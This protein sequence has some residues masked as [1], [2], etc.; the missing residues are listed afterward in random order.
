MLIAEEIWIQ[1]FMRKLQVH[2]QIIKKKNIYKRGSRSFDDSTDFVL[3]CGN[4]GRGWRYSFYLTCAANHDHFKQK[5]RRLMVSPV[6]CPG[7]RTWPRQ[8]VAC[9][10]VKNGRGSPWSWWMVHWIWFHVLAVSYL[11]SAP[12]SMHGPSSLMDTGFL[13]R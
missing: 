11:A 10:P 4:S 12:P 3:L 7:A 1:D 5:E 13:L 2:K 6:I 9:G 8:T